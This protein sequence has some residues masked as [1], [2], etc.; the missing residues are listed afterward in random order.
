VSADDA[1]FLA[2]MSKNQKT[3]LTNDIKHNL[4]EGAKLPIKNIKKSGNFN[5]MNVLKTP[6]EE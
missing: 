3:R 6:E 4:E 2:G 1:E 5:Y